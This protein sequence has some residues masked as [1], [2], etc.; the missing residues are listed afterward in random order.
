MSAVELQFALDFTPTSGRRRKAARSL[1][2]WPIEPDGITVCVPVIDRRVVDSRNWTLVEAVDYPI[3][4]SRAWYVETAGYAISHRGGVRTS[5]AATIM[6]P[7][8][9]MFVDHVDGERLDN[10]RRCLRCVTPSVNSANRRLR[11]GSTSRYRGVTR[12]KKTGKWQAG[13]NHAGRFH[14]AGLFRREED[15]AR[16]Y[17]RLAA[18]LWPGIVRPNL[19]TVS[20]EESMQR[21]VHLMLD[22]TTKGALR[23]AEVTEGGERVEQADSVVGTIYLRKSV[24]AGAETPQRITVTIA[25]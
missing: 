17:D 7:S 16:A 1:G 8:A 23:F 5:L 12:H 25:A 11:P 6:E 19:P 15:A 4:M 10:R 3:A 24:L 13:A 9:G 2:P 18:R 14:H 21:T 20:T 22:K